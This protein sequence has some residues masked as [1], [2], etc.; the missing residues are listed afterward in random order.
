MNKKKKVAILTQSLGFNYG[1]I[2]QNYAL[3]KVLKDLGYKAITIDRNIENPHPKLKIFLSRYKKIITG[4]LSKSKTI[5]FLHY[6]KISVNNRRFIRKNISI[7][8]K[9]LTT[10]SL[11]DYFNKKK[12]DVVVVGSDQVWRPS[13]SPNIYNF[14]LD[15][16][17]DKDNIKKVAYAASF[18]TEEWEFSDGE[19][20]ICGEL[21]QNFDGISVR[22]DSGIILCDKYLHRQDAEHVLDPTLLLSEADY[23]KLIAKKKENIGLFTYILDNSENKNEFINHCS[24]ILELS[25]HRNQ[26]KLPAENIIV[27]QLSDYIIPPIERWLQGFRD[28][29]FVVTDSFHGMVFSIINSKPFL[30][31]VN[32]SRGASRFESLLSKLDLEDRLIYDAEDFDFSILRKEIDYSP[33]SEKLNRLKEDSFHFINKYF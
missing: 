21:I 27:E 7:S 5:D 8:P 33:V 26:A 30:V 29:E 11:K 28:A 16:L 1:G 4:Y 2:I 23:S 6:R 12:F 15:F 17:K 20:E 18:G 10:Q 25:I 31:L 14:F 19:T 9:I 22:E 32:K 24:S 3:Q 13:Y